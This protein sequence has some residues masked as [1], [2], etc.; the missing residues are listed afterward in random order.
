MQRCYFYMVYDLYRI[1]ITKMKEKKKS[2]AATGE[3]IL[4]RNIYTI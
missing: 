3:N 1:D 2:M 4:N